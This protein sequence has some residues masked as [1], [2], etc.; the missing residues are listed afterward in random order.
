VRTKHQL[1]LDPNLDGTQKNLDDRRYGGREEQRIP[2]V[3]GGA[4][5]AEGGRPPESEAM[6][7]PLTS[8]EALNKTRPQSKNEALVVDL[9]RGLDS[10]SMIEQAYSILM[11]AAYGVG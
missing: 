3:G 7:L 6:I 5:A 9:A 1:D 4:G 8:D 10:G 11:K 2:R